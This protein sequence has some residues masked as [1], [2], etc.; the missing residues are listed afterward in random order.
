MIL[1]SNVCEVAEAVKGKFIQI[2][3][4]IPLLQQQNSFKCK[5]KVKKILCNFREKMLFHF[6]VHVLYISRATRSTLC[7]RD[8]I[9]S[10]LLDDRNS[11]I[12][13]TNQ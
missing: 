8:I 4:V 5:K 9:R 1:T 12:N 11:N 10:L 3:V 2:T 6:Q 13:A 7:E